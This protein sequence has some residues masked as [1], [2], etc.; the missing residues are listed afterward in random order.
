MCLVTWSTSFSCYHFPLFVLESLPHLL[1]VLLHYQLLLPSL[2]PFFFGFFLILNSVF[3]CMTGSYS[4]CHSFASRTFPWRQLDVWFLNILLYFFFWWWPWLLLTSNWFLVKFF[5]WLLS[6]ILFFLL[7]Y[8]LLARGTCFSSLFSLATLCALFALLSYSWSFTS[9][10]ATII[11][12]NL[13][14]GFVGVLMKN[15]AMPGWF[16]AFS[17]GNGGN[18]V[19][20]SSSSRMIGIGRDFSDS[21]L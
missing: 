16:A 10:L 8:F 12:C 14:F 2:S 7:Y 20:S 15:E 3:S 5:S 4:F 9:R 13:S 11:F 19:S 6:C 1:W 17:L 18:F 21:L